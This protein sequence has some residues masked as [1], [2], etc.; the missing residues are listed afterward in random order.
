MNKPDG[1]NLLL[2]K[3]TRVEMNFQMTVDWYRALNKANY[4]LL[5]EE[6][7]NA[8]LDEIQYGFD[9]LKARL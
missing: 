1:N 8:T 3:L 6:E 2:Q 5:N 9:K 4:V 7:I